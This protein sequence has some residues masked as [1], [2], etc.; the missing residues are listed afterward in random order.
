MF[1]NGLNRQFGW[2]AVEE[3][4]RLLKGWMEFPISM[5]GRTRNTGY[6]SKL[7][8]ALDQLVNSLKGGQILH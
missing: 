5:V 3:A 1:G 2:A 8:G 4:N 7:D 6:L